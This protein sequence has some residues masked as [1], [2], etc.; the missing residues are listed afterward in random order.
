MSKTNLFNTL[1]DQEQEVVS[2]GYTY[3]ASGA[4]GSVTKV[5]DGASGYY[6]YVA[7]NGDTHVASWSPAGFSYV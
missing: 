3:T 4:W 6:K 1:S 7:P 5:V 2:G